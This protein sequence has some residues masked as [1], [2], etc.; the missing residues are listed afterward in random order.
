MES[1][2]P[3]AIAFLKQWAPQGPWVLTAINPERGG[4]E[5]QRIQT[6]T[7]FPDKEKECGV[8]I[9]QWQGNRNIYFTVNHVREPMNSKPEKKDIGY[10]VALHVDIDPVNPPA[11]ADLPIFYEGEQQRILTML[12]AYTPPPSIITYSGGGYQGFWLLKEP[13]EI[14]EWAT[15]ESYNKRPQNDMGG[16][17]CFNIDR[18]MRLPGTINVPDAKK[19][20]KGRTE[21]LAGI[22]TADWDLLYTLG[23]FKPWA[24]PITVAPPPPKTTFRKRE[25]VEWTTRLI[26]QGNDPEGNHAYAGD[27]SK[28]VWAVCCSLV[29]ADW[30]DEDIAAAITDPGNKI[31]EHVLH[32]SDP[33]KYALRQ[34]RKARQKAGIEFQ[35]IVVG[36]GDDAKDKIIPNQFNIQVALAKLDI[37]MTYNAFSA[38]A[39]IEGPYGEPNRYYDDPEENKLYLMIDAVYKFRTSFEFFQKV[40]NNEARAQTYHPVREYLSKLQWDS[41]ERIDTWLTD[42]AAALD[43][44]YSRAVGA[45]MLVAGV[46]RVMDPGCKFDEMMVFI[47]N[48]GTDKSTALTVMAVK[49]EWF[50]DSLPLNV[51]D[52]QTIEIL[53]GKWIGEAGEL[54]GMKTGNIEHLK[55]FLSRSTD[56][57][58]LSYGR[59]LSEVPRQCIIFGTTNSRTFL[60]DTTGNRRFWPVAVEQ[61]NIPLLR[62]NRDQL[63]AEAAFREA[64]GDSIRLDPELYAYAAEEQEKATVDEPWAETID[65]ELGEYKTGK[66]LCMDM[67]EILGIP[68]ERRTQHLKGRL[69]EAMRFLE[70]GREKTRSNGVE[71]T[72]W[73]YVKGTAE[74]RKFRISIRRDWVT[75]AVSVGNWQEPDMQRDIPL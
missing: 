21:A 56:R 60:L 11:G 46:R 28:A 17:Y 36:K 12:Q 13:I 6:R 30:S 48:Q 57:A 59:H 51:D 74:E 37:N 23:D 69:G 49:E 7:F 72:K 38:R 39:M 52:K 73:H 45:L 18:V 62:A 20:A 9:N 29:R 27:R 55:A 33:A 42:H 15:F 2:T 1:S 22:V 53:S 58:R 25:P 26:A 19:R 4:N 75:G 10:G 44:P 41:I 71:G 54:K 35:I 32:Q 64:R 40:M 66:I 50:T 61:F 67:W 65:K 47:S 5:K 14:E 3:D 16:D 24:D 63:W 31:S 43:T 70:W 8:W 68:V 34:A